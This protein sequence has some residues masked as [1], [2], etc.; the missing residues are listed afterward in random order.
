MSE[1]AIQP[2]EALI[3]TVRTSENL[4]EESWRERFL[5]ENL[6]HTEH[7][8]EVFSKSD[9][10]KIL[11]LQLENEFLNEKSGKNMGER[12]ALAI[13]DKYLGKIHVVELGRTTNPGINGEIDG[14]KDQYRDLLRWMKTEGIVDDEMSRAESGRNISTRKPVE[15]EAADKLAIMVRNRPLINT[16]IE[17]EGTKLNIAIAKRMVFG[18]PRNALKAI[19]AIDEDL[20]SEKTQQFIEERYLKNGWG[21][22]VPIRTAY[23]LAT[24]LS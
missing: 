18:L 12:F 13:S 23:Y 1:F 6:F 22:V 24:Q 20:N 16:T 3:E 14:L 19:F 10:D 4:K 15:E 11:L 9:D 2:S 21:G 8:E 5:A 17:H 7:L